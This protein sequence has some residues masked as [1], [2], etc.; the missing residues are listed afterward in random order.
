MSIPV[1]E[2]LMLGRHVFSW[3]SAAKNC[4]YPDVGLHLLLLVGSILAFISGRLLLRADT[5]DTG[6]EGEARSGLHLRGARVRLP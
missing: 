5:A 6:P 1:L 4:E 2:C 3:G